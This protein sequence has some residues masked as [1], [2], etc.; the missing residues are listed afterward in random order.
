MN[1]TLVQDLDVETVPELKYRLRR[2]YLGFESL[3][4]PIRFRNIRIRELPA[5]ETW[6]VAL[7]RSGGLCQMAGVVRKADLRTARRHPARRRQRTAGDARDLPRL[8]PAPLRP[9]RPASQRRRHVPLDSES[10][11]RPGPELRD[12]AARRRRRALRD[13]IALFVQARPLPRIEPEQW[14]LLQLVVQGPPLPGPH[15]RRHV[16]EYEGLQNLEPG[17][18]ELQAHDA[19]KWIEYKQI[20]IRPL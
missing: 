9:R 7:R 2:G 20:K 6:Q 3:S 17:R 19:G 5:K 8:R 15:Q 16:L 10:A 12:S 11:G 1:D 4:Y 14:F 18:I 13:R